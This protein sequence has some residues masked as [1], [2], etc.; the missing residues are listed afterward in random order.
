MEDIA[1]I[2]DGMELTFSWRDRGKLET[3]YYVVGKKVICAMVEKYSQVREW[4]G[5]SGVRKLKKVVFRQSQPLGP[6]GH[7]FTHSRVR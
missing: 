5:R 2:L 6:G 1:K 4:W 3:Q 7:S